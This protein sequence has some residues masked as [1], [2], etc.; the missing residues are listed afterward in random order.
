MEAISKRLS[1]ESYSNIL[2]YESL[3]LKS[4][5]MQEKLAGIF[6]REILRDLVYLRTNIAFPILDFVS[7]TPISPL[8]CF[9][10]EELSMNFL[11]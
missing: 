8:D 2:I 3:M 6:K 5:K 11:A 1:S 10:Q 4:E 7:L 9:K